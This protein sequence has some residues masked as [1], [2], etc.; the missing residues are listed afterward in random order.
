MGRE[1]DTTKYNTRYKQHNTLQPG[2]CGDNLL[3]LQQITTKQRKEHTT[4]NTIN[5]VV[6]V[7]KNHTQKKPR[8][9]T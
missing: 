2:H 7:H 6:V 1:V 5:K 9:R 4:N 3:D 8:I